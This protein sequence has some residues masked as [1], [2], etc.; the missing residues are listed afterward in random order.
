MFVKGKSTLS[1]VL[2]FLMC[3]S[4][5][6][7]PVFS[8]ETIPET[9]TESTLQEEVVEAVKENSETEEQVIAFEDGNYV[10]EADLA[11]RSDLDDDSR[12][13]S[14]HK[15]TD[16]E[17]EQWYKKDASYANEKMMSLEFNSSDAYCVSGRTVLRSETDAER[18]ERTQFH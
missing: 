1:W 14:V 6:N 10:P 16:E 13:S 8:E 17:L 9:G 3:L 7:L 2:S 12:D 11:D 5:F 15:M 4:S 18:S